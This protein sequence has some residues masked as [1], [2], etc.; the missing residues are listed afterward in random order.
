MSGKEKRRHV[1]GKS[2][3]MVHESILLEKKRVVFQVLKK[4]KEKRRH[5]MNFIYFVYDFHLMN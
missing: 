3:F 1:M 4:R 2:K 5:L